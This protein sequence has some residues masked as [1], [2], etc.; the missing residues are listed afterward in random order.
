MAGGRA[1]Q[2]TATRMADTD[3]PTR[4][5]LTLPPA[6]AALLQAEYERAASILEYGSGGSTV[7]AGEM[8]GKTVF[9]VEND[10][11]WAMAM[12]RWF[13]ENPPV[14]AVTVHHEGVGRT[15][16]WGRLVDDRAWK[17]WH[18]YPLGVWELEGFVHPDVVL[19]DGRFRYACLLSTLF[20]IERDVVVL[21]DDYTAR[22]NYQRVE[23]FVKPVEI[24]DRMARFELSP[25]PIPRDQIATFIRSFASPF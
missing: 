22:A 8:P 19:I 17:R 5:E 6:A 9:S 11:G 16:R 21:F 4:P 15:K 23:A 20:R 18:R 25:R 24:V 7:L 13:E 2:K 14:S 12:R 3:A 10:H 1:A